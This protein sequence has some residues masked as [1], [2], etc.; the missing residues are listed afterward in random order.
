MK[1]C[2]VDYEAVR[3][4]L[5]DHWKPFVDYTLDCARSPG[6]KAALRVMM[7]GLAVPAI[8]SAD[9]AHISAPTTLIWGRHD[10]VTR[11]TVAETASKRYGW[12]LH[13]IDGAGDDPPLEQPTAFLKALKDGLR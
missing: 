8:P 5:G 6:G 2:T 4:G 10:P 3:A 1:R 12:P 13:V 11:L 9:L 7:R